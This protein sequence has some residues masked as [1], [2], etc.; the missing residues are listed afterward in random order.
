YYGSPAY[1]QIYSELKR[2]ERLGLVTSR[3]ENTGGMRN[4][5][6]YKITEAGL[7][8]VTRWANDT[9]VDRPTLKHGALLRVTLGHLA[10]PARL[11]E[12]LQDHVAYADEMHRKA[13]KDARW[14]GADPCW[15]YAR[16]ALQWAE[17]YYANERELALKL[18]KELDEAEAVFPRASDGETT[19]IPWPAPEFWYEI[20]K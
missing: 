11:K 12:L 5:R 3:V 15:A 10:S 20:E 9:P 18:I 4:R 1:S 6:L 13:A 16:I 19:K 2:L 14:A 7:A 8:A 17:R